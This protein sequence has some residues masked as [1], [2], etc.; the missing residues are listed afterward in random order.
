MQNALRLGVM[1]LVVAMTAVLLWS[2]SFLF[3]YGGVNE[4]WDVSN[5]IFTIRV[6]NY[7]S[8]PYFKSSYFVF[9]S[10]AVGSASWREVAAYPYDGSE[11]TIPMPSDQV[12]FVGSD[13]GYFSLESIFA[14]TT[15]RGL[16][17]TVWRPGEWRSSE[18]SG[19]AYFQPWRLEDV[20]INSDGSGSAKLWVDY[21]RVRESKVYR[22]AATKDY[23]RQWNVE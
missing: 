9:Q 6:Q 18:A 7:R 3:G 11:I 12:R 14:V 5:G 8:V 17:W 19:D 23:G 22:K 15:D 13:I 1:F 16:N 21:D 4:Q 2:T 10:A 20:V